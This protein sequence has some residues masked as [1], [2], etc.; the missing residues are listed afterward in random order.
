MTAQ[1]NGQFGAMPNAKIIIGAAGTGK[2]QKIL[3]LTAD[4]AANDTSYVVV[5]YTNRAAKVL[6]ERGIPA[7]TIHKTLYES[8]KKDPEEYTE[9][10]IPVFDPTTRLPQRDAKGQI[11]L[12]HIAIG[13]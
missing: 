2:T 7:S 12:R 13:V 4:M 8:R 9:V 6:R 5:A 11:I 10:M 3:E 1:T